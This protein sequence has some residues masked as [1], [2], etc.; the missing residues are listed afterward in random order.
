[1]SSANFRSAGEVLVFDWE[2]ARLADAC[3]PES[4][5]GE[6]WLARVAPPHPIPTP[7]TFLLLPLLLLA[8]TSLRTW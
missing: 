3:K 6:P 7:T 5:C 4:E 1:M 2:A 8:L